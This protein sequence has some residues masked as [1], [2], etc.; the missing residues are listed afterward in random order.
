MTVPDGDIRNFFLEP[1][2]VTNIPARCQGGLA[3]LSDWEGEEVVR[4]AEA[5]HI[6]KPFGEDFLN[7]IM[8][9]AAIWWRLPYQ[10]LTLIVSF[11]DWIRMEFLKTSS[12]TRNAENDSRDESIGAAPGMWRRGC[13]EDPEPY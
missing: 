2:L 7:K 9:A 6:G 11:Q 8:S 4:C 5:A 10:I 3:L 1:R 13:E 12:F